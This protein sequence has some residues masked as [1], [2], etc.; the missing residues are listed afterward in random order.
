MIFP[1]GYG[2]AGKDGSVPPV[3]GD[4]GIS[5][6]ISDLF[7]ALQAEQRT[8]AS[9]RCELQKA[10]DEISHLRDCLRLERNSRFVRCEK[11]DAQTS[12]EEV[13]SPEDAA[14]SE[15]LQQ[16]EV[17]PHA[18]VQHSQQQQQPP[19]NGAESEALEPSGDHSETIAADAGEAPEEDASKLSI[20]GQLDNGPSTASKG[21]Y[22]RAADKV[23]WVSYEDPLQLIRLPSADGLRSSRGQEDVARQETVRDALS[24][25]RPLKR[26]EAEV[27]LPG[28]PERR[29]R[30]LRQPSAE[31]CFSARGVLQGQGVAVMQVP[32]A[33]T[34]TPR[35][36]PAFSHFAPARQARQVSPLPWQ[37]QSLQSERRRSS[38]TQCLH[39]RHSLLQ[40]QRSGSLHSSTRSLHPPEV[41][42]PGSISRV[43]CRPWLTT[44]PSQLRACSSSRSA[45]V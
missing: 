9:L 8:S 16:L 4:W 21:S 34:I 6:S 44:M 20:A 15:Q 43:Y 5:W 29:P 22:V 12:Q 13:I 23:Y 3:G 17:Q 1:H 18:E 38:S 11:K 24:S 7:Q 2:P 31:R 14:A 40:R 19:A 45:V 36:V 37:A 39:A 10:K 30:A 41:G 28:T 33:R 27:L 35:P 42:P 25:S 26:E 32:I